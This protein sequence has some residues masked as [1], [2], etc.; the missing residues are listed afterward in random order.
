LYEDLG[1]L[2]SWTMKLSFIFLLVA[3]SLVSYGSAGENTR[4]REKVE[5]TDYRSELEEK[6]KVIIEVR[7]KLSRDFASAKDKASKIKAMARKLFEIL[8]ITKSPEENL[9]MVKVYYSDFPLGE[10]ITK[11]LLESVE[12]ELKKG[13]VNS[14]AQALEMLE[15]VANAAP[16]AA[17]SMYI[18]S[19][20]VV[21][22][23]YMLACGLN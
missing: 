6:Q 13:N 12:A 22:T 3:L 2:F 11:E 23:T 8:D 20:L 4:E 18:C 15:S 1:E 21:I 10:Q 17:Q 14:V 16:S 5:E 19:A 7:D 9:D